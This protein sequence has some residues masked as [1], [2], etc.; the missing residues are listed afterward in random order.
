MNLTEAEDAQRRVQQGAQLLD[1][2]LGPDWPSRIR[3]T[4]DLNS[5]TDCILGQLYRPQADDLMLGQEHRP[6]YRGVEALWPLLEGEQLG[7]CLPCLRIPQLRA[8]GFEGL[9]PADRGLLERAWTELVAQ[10][11]A[12]PPADPTP[13]PEGN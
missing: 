3:S 6:F 10:R 11:Q 12:A 7:C 2:D 13:N 4:I 8:S 1:A 9:D 5:M